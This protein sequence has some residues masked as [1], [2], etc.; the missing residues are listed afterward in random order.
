MVEKNIE[1]TTKETKQLELR[2]L[3]KLI[4]KNL[5]VKVECNYG[6]QDRDCPL[7]ITVGD[8]QH[9]Q[10]YLD[11]GGFM[12][13]YG[14]CKVKE[15]SLQLIASGTLVLV[16]SIWKDTID[17]QMEEPYWKAASKRANS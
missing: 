9:Q 5:Y 7:V 3:L 4:N 11:D 15:I 2:G 6:R 1:Q 10:E 16:V 13:M 17:E 8:L 14:E 12:E